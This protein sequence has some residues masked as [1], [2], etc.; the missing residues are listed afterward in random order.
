MHAVYDLDAVLHGQADISSSPNS[1]AELVRLLVHT[2]LQLTVYH[3]NQR[4]QYHG[5]ISDLR[6]GHAGK[7]R[8]LK[9]DKP[10]SIPPV[11]NCEP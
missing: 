8:R 2:P 3:V 1:C 4:K 9:K 6:R 11:M 7:E 5:E 10:P